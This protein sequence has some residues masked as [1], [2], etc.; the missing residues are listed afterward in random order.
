MAV[1]A[2][3][4]AYLVGLFAFPKSFRTIWLIAGVVVCA[5]PAIVLFIAARRVKRVRTTIPETAAELRKLSNDRD[6]RHALLELADQNDNHASATPL[7]KLGQE[8]NA[9]RKAVTKHKDQLI[10]AW[11][12]I[13]ALT[14]LP[15]L[16][17]IGT[18]GT[19]GLFAFSA[20]AVVV[21]LLLGTD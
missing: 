7:I 19:F 12:N 16:V 9:L 5:I 10:N 20:I 2:A 8:L 21:R 18:I 11:Q 1:A 3:I 15:G 4:L 14:T 6:V 17:A 13:T